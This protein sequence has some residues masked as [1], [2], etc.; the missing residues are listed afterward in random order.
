MN[1]W[2]PVPGL[3]VMAFLLLG[4]CRQGT[5]Q[6]DTEGLRRLR[7]HVRVLSAEIGPRPAGSP[8]DQKAQEYILNEMARLGL[9]AHGDSIDR[10][11]LSP[12]KEVALSTANLVGILPGEL[13]GTLLVGSHHD[14]RNE[15]CPGASDDASGVA[16]MLEAAR[17]LASRPRRHTLAFVSFGG[18]ET[19]GLP[20]SREFL[21]T[22]KGPPVRLA[23]TLDFVGTGQLFVAPFPRSPE[24]WANRMLLRAERESPTARVWFDPWLVILPRLISFQFAADHESFLEAGIPALNLSCQFPAWIYHTTEDRSER[25]EGE[26]LLAARDL[27]FR[28]VAE[29]DARIPRTSRGGE[30]YLPWTLFGHVLFLPAGA[31]LGTTVAVALLAL[32][33]LGRFRRELA[34]LSGLTEGLRGILVALPLT[35]LAISGPFV[36]EGVLE[37]SSGTL[38]PGHAHPGSH[39][40]GGMLAAAFT[41]WLSLYLARFLRPS[42]LAGAYLV[43]ALLLEGSLACALVAARRTDAAFPFLVGTGVML[44][45]S[46]SRYALRRAGLGILGVAALLPFLSPTTYRMFLELSGVTLP[47]FALE[48]AAGALF[49]PWFL[50]IQ[51][52]ACMPEALYARPGGPIFRPVTGLALAVLAV[53]G[54][55]ANAFRPP[56]DGDHRALVT[57]SEEIDLQRHHAEAAFSSLESLETVRLEGLPARSLPDSQEARIRV[58]FPRLGIPGLDVQMESLGAGEERVRVH[59]ASP[60][61]PRRIVLRLRSG[62][63]LQVE[64]EGKWQEVEEFS[65]VVFPS[66]KEIDETFHIRRDSSEALVLAADLAYDSDLLELRPRGAFRTFRIESR[67]RFQ[68]RLS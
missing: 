5:P 51:H 4:G 34:S 16:V 19:F 29:A 21:R 46:W 38:N 33:T 49:F 68:K 7:E 27:V 45:A 41:L 3:A 48:A 6:G 9:E 54:A 56:Y 32:A 42:N 18:E 31:L 62:K 44:L 2:R 30:G 20:G 55:W 66:E 23:I 36:V 28:M 50:F 39:L 53:L 26:T 8:G 58:P 47:R 10:V 14:S 1:R 12:G 37:R 25:V 40:A 24:L 15:S 35:V 22:W 64:Q 65:R 63:R 60:G 11:F 61:I 67:V 13:Q 17:L 59:G 43:P 57:V 52:L